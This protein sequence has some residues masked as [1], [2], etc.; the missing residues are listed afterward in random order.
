MKLPDRGHVRQFLER[1]L[2]LRLRLLVFKAMAHALPSQVGAGG[3]LRMAAQFAEAGR[4]REAMVCWRILHGMA[5]ADTR[6]FMRRVSAALDA[7]DTDEVDKAVEDST[8]AGIPPQSFARVAGMLA[9]HDF[10]E[11]AGRVLERL[12]RIPGGNR[13][14]TQSPSIVSSGIPDDIR[15]LAAALVSSDEDGC[16]DLLPLARLSFTFRDSATAAALFARASRV[17]SLGALD[18][19][20][21]LYSLARTNPAGLQGTASELRALMDYLR[22]HPDALG[23][24]GKIALVAGDLDLAREAVRLAL[25]SRYGAHG[26]ELVA[27]CTAIIEVLAS[28][29]TL[30]PMLPPMLL[31]RV[32]PGAGG[33]PKIFLCG[34]GW[35]GSGA[36]YDAIRATPG[37]CEFEGAGLDEIINE[38]A[39]SE[40]MFVQGT[41]G[42]GDLWLRALE[43]KRI[44]WHALWDTFILHVAGL[45]PTGYAQYKSAAAA[46]NHIRR[47][48]TL[49]MRPFRRFLEDYAALR[50]DPREGALHACLLNATESLCSML[51]SQS[52]ANAVLFNNAVFGRNAAMLEIFRSY[53]AAIVYRDPRDVYVDRREKD[54]NH[55]RTPGQLASYYAHGL[56]RYVRYKMA[57]KSGTQSLREVPFERFVGDDGFRSCVL[58]WLLGD[59]ADEP[60]GSHFDPAVSRGNIG[61]HAGVLGAAEQRQLKDAL[62]DCRALDGLSVVAWESKEG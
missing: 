57:S 26:D 4:A 3:F 15:R 17:A 46:R 1:I 23:M 9:Q 29:R 42:L 48:G 12:A 31:E 8:V 7:G 10:M 43:R 59:A 40:V 51:V 16:G 58:T 60:A 35:S 20:A 6:I 32:M 36:V 21:M 55:W 11:G 62:D 28:V 52:G 50:R 44:S 5:P 27:N 54:L 56:H 61:I 25:H 30:D 41:G 34:F 22:D 18:R 2:P 14:V 47:Y 33:V 19:V 24:L 53:R 45:S 49:Y 13:H 38:D 37:L 39:E